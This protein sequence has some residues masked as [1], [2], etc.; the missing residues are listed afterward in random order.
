MADDVTRALHRALTELESERQR[1][2][3]K[4][5][6]IRA[7]LDSGFDGQTTMG[8]RRGRRRRPTMSAAARRA[9][10]ERMKKYWAARRAEK[11][12][13]AKARAERPAAK[14]AS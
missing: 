7:V 9:V 10:S 8:P 1:L 5:T 3:H 13:K 6:A 4:I 12:G 11:A 14:R 2:D